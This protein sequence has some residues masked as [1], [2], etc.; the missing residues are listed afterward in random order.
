VRAEP[1]DDAVARARR[2]AAFR[3]GHLGPFTGVPADRRVDGAAARQHAL[4]DRAVGA[5]D[6][7]PL[8]CR[9][10]RRV[11]RQRARNEQ[12]AARILVEPVHETGA[13]EQLELR[14]AVQQ[15]VLQR[16]RAV[17]GAGVHDE[18]DGLVDDEQGIVGVHDRQRYRLGPRLDGRFELRLQRQ[19]FAAFDQHAGFGLAPADFERARVDPGPQTASR[20]LGQQ[21][22]GG[23]VEAAARELRGDR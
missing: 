20:V 16:A 10:Q 5:L 7:A 23:L 15:R 12:Q 9:R 8:E 6:L 1:L 18:A 2:A 17:P 14:I 13:R 22:R 4:A 19:L 3:D 21:L 11:A